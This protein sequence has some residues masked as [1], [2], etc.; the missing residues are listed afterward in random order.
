MLV[1]AECEPEGELRVL[2]VRLSAIGDAVLTLPVLNALR[3]HYP[4]AH[5]AWAVQPG[6]ATVLR[7]HRALDQLIEL[8]RGWMTSPRKSLAVCRALRAFRANVCL[9]V[10]GLA[11]SALPAL[12]SGAR[13]RIG[14]ARGDRDGREFSTW[15]NNELVAPEE[16]HVVDRNL[17]LLR[18]L[19]ITRPAVRFDVPERA[20][21][22]AMVA[23]FRREHGLED[24]FAVLNLGASL[25]S[26]RWPEEHY[27]QVARHLVHERR[28]PIVAPWGIEEDRQRAE[29]MV[30]AIGPGAVVF[31]RSS[32]TALGSLLKQA[33]IFVGSD[34]G[35]LHLAVA[36]GTRCVGLYGSTPASRSGPYGPANII[37]CRNRVENSGSPRGKDDDAMRLITVADATEACDRLLD[38]HAAA[39]AA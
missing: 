6:P 28:L 34:T 32:L 7:G 38:S 19:G 5:I 3:D 16:S 39:D 27:T 14:F 21:E 18:P 17:A 35:P 13:R 10:Q 29:R 4:Q 26:K 2:I 12:L 1:S 23:A 25:P 9:D 11:K 30:S 8:P 15:L 24:G 37:L 36:V 33:S 20:D 31:P 22:L